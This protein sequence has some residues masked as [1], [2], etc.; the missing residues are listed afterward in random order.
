MKRYKR[1]FIIVLMIL[2][3]LYYAAPL[4]WQKGQNWVDRYKTGGMWALSDSVTTSLVYPVK[5][6][7]WLTFAIP[8]GTRQLRIISNAHITKPD[9]LNPEDSWKYALRYQLLD[10][11]GKIIMDELY[12]QRSRLTAYKDKQGGI[13]FGNFYSGRGF[14]PL[15]G[16]LILLSMSKIQQATSVRLSFVRQNTEV[17]EIA[18]RFYIPDKVAEHLIGSIW[19]RM[20]TKQKQILAKHSVY[21]PVLLTE[22][23]KYNLLKNKWQAMGPK[24]IQDRDYSAKTLYI[25]KEI[26]ADRLE[27][28]FI[29]AE[30]LQIYPQHPGIVAILEQGGKL[31]L[32]LKALDGS[33]LLHPVDLELSWF[34]RTR[35]QRWLRDAQWQSENSELNYAVEGGLLQ[36]KASEQVLVHAF[37]ETLD[38]Q[39][40][41]ITPKPLMITAYQASP[42]VDYQ[43]LHAYG[44]TTPM[45]IDIRRVY[46]ENSVNSEAK[47]EYQ[48]LDD[49]KQLI[50]NGTLAIN[51]EPSNYDRFKGKTEDLKVSDPVSYYFN[52]PSNISYIRLISRQN[53][54]WVN[55]YNQPW[56]YQKKQRVPESSYVSLDKK[57]WY[58]AWFLLRP[59]NEQSLVKQQSM[60]KIAAQYRPPEDELLADASQYLWEDFRPQEQTE[61]RYLLTPQNSLVYRDQALASV[62]CQ[63]PVNQS[64]AISFKAYG[65]LAGVSPEL[66]Y[67]RTQKSVF[68]VSFSV[69]ERIN[70]NSSAIGQQG[71]FRLVE[72]ITGDHAIKINTQD[73]GQWLMNYISACSTEAFLKRRVFKLKDRQLTF[74]YSNDQAGDKTLSARFYAAEDNE[75]R[76]VIQVAI[77]PLEK[78]ASKK[79]Q[80]HWTFNKRSY[81]IRA[82]E[83]EPSMVLDNAEHYL[84]SGESFFIPFKRDMPAGLYQITIALKQGA[85]G[86]LSLSQIKP[87]LYQ[88]R[89][90]YRETND[91]SL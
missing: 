4:L 9:I 16:R 5:P 38:S 3:I 29:I 78:I 35:D 60:G 70:F 68:D 26:E 65:N 86:Y 31:T 90:F 15:D 24:G 22:S 61:A 63:L 34:G 7:K 6:A 13:F 20:N 67:L 32:Q 12:H 51:F 74:L 49:K 81:D 41:N 2:F 19:L 21:P 46:D 54:I 42:G 25:L 33:P 8:K 11:E 83:G 82:P 45:R 56:H 39:I 27:E 10:S 64:Y 40:I 62:Y 72:Q 66:I 53:D 28:N 87:G 50:E 47:V 36:I 85:S 58:P 44:Q 43:L 89:R 79:I 57:H 59:D 75:V 77:E 48:W 1:G 88:Q 17:E 84:N 52:V 14:T 69:D 37:L 91:Q 23:E 30:G 80:Q 55:A 73:G 18:I 71:S 76:S